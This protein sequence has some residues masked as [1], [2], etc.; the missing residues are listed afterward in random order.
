[1]HDTQVLFLDTKL[2]LSESFD[3]RH[4]FDVTDRSTQ[5]Q[6]EEVVE[7]RINSVDLT[8]MMQMSGSA[9]LSSTEIRATRSTHS[10][11]ASVI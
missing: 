8:S 9:E 10:C 11:M 4:T 5:L 7:K 6:R 1:M 3:E 2:E